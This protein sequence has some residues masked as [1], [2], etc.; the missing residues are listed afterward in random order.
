LLILVAEPIKQLVKQLMAIPLVIQGTVEVE[1]KVF[2]LDS[3]KG[4]AW[5]ETIV[6]FRFEPAGDGKPCTIRREP[7]G[8]WYGCRKVAGKVRKKYIGKT[9]EVNVPRLEEIAEALEVPPV[10]QVDKVA[11]VAQEVTEVAQIAQVA[12]DRLTVL[13]LEVADLRKALEALQEGLPGKSEPGNPAELP[14]V[15]NA[16][17]EQLQNELSNLKAEN[18]KLKADYGNSK[19][20]PK[21]SG[22]VAE[23]LQNDLSNLKA[24]SELQNELSN[25]KTENEKLRADYAALLE[26]STHVTNKLRGEVQELRSQLEKERADREEV[27]AE[28]EELAQLKKQVKEHALEIHREGRSIELEKNRWQGQLSEARAD[29]AAAQATIV[30]QKG[31][32]LELERGYTLKPNPA[33][34]RLRLEIGELQTELSD[35]KQKLAAAGKDLPEAAE[36][37]NQLKAKRKKSKADLTD[38][39]AILEIL[40][41]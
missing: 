4:I 34:R 19:E 36:L 38:L 20:L 26:S 24:E 2:E 13:E 11:E 10:P 18:E 41:S 6:S 37:L 3:P 29:L 15:G 33:E 7:S 22:E 8:Y 27:E 12:Q 21:V 16:V 23:E 14:K 30:Q 9:S 35:L 32:I 40:E 28:R 17:A 25:L 31:K 39:E 5:L 1:G